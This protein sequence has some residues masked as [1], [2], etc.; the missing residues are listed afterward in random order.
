MD[1]NLTNTPA[2]RLLFLGA[3]FVIVIAGMKAAASLLVPFMLSIFLAIVFAQ[4]FVWLQ[5]KKVPTWLALV[6]VVVGIAL[7]GLVLIAIIGD[8]VGDFTQNMPEYQEKLQTQLT[9]VLGWLQGLGIELPQDKLQSYFDVGAIMKLVAQMLSGLGNVLTDS[10]LIIL[11]VIFI[12]MEAA[13]FRSKLRKAFG[14]PDRPLAGINE[15]LST[16]KSYMAMKSLTSL[17]TGVLVAVALTIIGVD[18]PILWGLLAFLLNYVPTIGSIIAAIPA[19]LLS[20]I[21]LG[22][23][24]TLLTIGVYLFVNTVI[25]NVVEP[26]IMGKGLGLSTLV[27]FISLVFWGWVLGT[28]GMFLSVPLTMMVKIALHSNE[29][30]RKIALLLGD[31]QTAALGEPTESDE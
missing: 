4:P 13:G 29:S 3:A 10:F 30:T 27:V 23:G 19:I 28:V 12:L 18:F 24:T 6:I 21:Q 26:K 25:G 2:A 1:K 15:F 9:T 7:M 31:A 20:F 5:S 22:P 8:S 17:A 11:T 16:V 14:D